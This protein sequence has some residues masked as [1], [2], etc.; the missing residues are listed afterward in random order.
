VKCGRNCILYLSVY[1][2]V[3]NCRRR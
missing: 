1:I 2:C 3:W